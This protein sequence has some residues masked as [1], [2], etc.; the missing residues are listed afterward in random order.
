M[1]ALPS[2]RGMASDF[3]RR[4]TWANMSARRASR[5]RLDSSSSSTSSVIDGPAGL[6]A[7]IET[8]LS[9][10]RLAALEAVDVPAIPYNTYSIFSYIFSI[11]G[12]NAGMLVSPLLSLLLW[13]VGWQLLFV[14][15]LDDRNSDVREQIAALDDLITPL[16]IP[17]SFLLTF[18]LGRAA[19]RFWD[20]RRSAGKMVEICRSNI[21]MVTVGFTSPIEL[22]N[23]RRKLQRPQSIDDKRE[24]QC[25]GEYHDREDALELLCE[26]AR[27]LAVFPIAVKHF[28]R[29]ATRKGWTNEVRYKKRRFEI[30]ELI[31]DED[32]RMV[33][34][35]YDTVDGKPTFDPTAVRAR[36]P[37]LVVL[38]RL[39]KLAYRLAHFEY[40][41]SSCSP[42]PQSRAIFYQQLT[43][44]LNILFGAYGA[45]ERIKLTP[46]PFAYAIHLRTFLL[47]YLFLWN[48]SSVA[49][50]GWVALPFLFLLNW[51]L[52]G[53]E[54]AAVECEKPFQ[55]N[56]NHLTLGKVSVV[57]ARNIGQCLRELAR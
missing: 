41:G 35:E 24:D 44:Q 29:P 25:D 42:T 43:D 37:P 51:A 12:R 31:S 46:L 7:T 9:P 20:A 55:Y 10:E 33:I 22:G 14:L 13:G 32:A 1:A 28:L 26:Y 19:V 56:P 52:L 21:A 38:N 57:I 11:R 23:E 36:D 8:I 15:W 54:A 34:M 40:E 6:D 47:L 30:G 18:R 16:L 5:G 4:T 17:L 45:M 49:A 39:H 3:S 50:L 53:I 2:K 48:M 27:W